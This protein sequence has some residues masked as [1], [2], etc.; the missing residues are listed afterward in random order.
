MSREL[1]LIPKARYERL[2]NQEELMEGKNMQNQN[3]H[4]MKNKES[5]ST[6]NNLIKNG[7]S[8]YNDLLTQS[9]NAVE[10]EKHILFCFSN[11]SIWFIMIYFLLIIWGWM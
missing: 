8:M 11:F 6:E 3:D 4:S 9:E 2:I 5:K 1:I 10:N 7:N